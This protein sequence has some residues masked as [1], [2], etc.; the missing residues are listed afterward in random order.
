MTR[1]SA[2]HRSEIATYMG[3]AANGSKTQAAK[4][5]ASVYRVSVSTV[6]KAAGLGGTKRRRQQLRPEYRDWTRTVAALAARPPGLSFEDA[7][8][9]AVEGGSLPPEAAAMPVATAR[10]LAREMGL[11]KRPPRTQRMDGDYPMQAVLIDWSTSQY[12]LADRPQGDDW[13]LRLNRR[14][15]PASGYKNRP[16]KGHR[17]RVGVYC[18]W[19]M[20]TGYTISRY[21]VSKGENAIDAMAFLC[22]ALGQDKDPRLRMHG[23]PDDLWSDLGPLARSDAAA[24]LLSRLGV[25]LITGQPYSKSRMGGVERQHRTRWESFEP[26]LFHRGT[27]TLTLSE[28]NDRLVEFEI[29]E[30][31]KRGGSRTL[32]AGRRPSR[33]E[34]WTALTNARPADNP[35]RLLPANPMETLATEARRV[36]D[37]NGIVRWGGVEYECEA[38]HSRPVIARRAADGSGD[39]ALEDEATGER[40]VARRYEPRPY[41]TVRQAAASPLDKLATERAHVRPVADLYA[42]RPAP[43]GNVTA[44]PTRSE[45]PAPLDNPLAA[46]RLGSAADAMRLFTSLCP[47][48]LSAANMRL[49]RERIVE[50]GLSRQAVTELAQELSALLLR[51]G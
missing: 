44:M 48:R 9:V 42:P 11:E 30:N 3:A 20:C 31:D 18:L 46:D 27:E 17:Q 1:L 47:K 29:L 6:Y 36:V 34:A 5:L 49:V 2:L 15:V 21:S 8:R 13:L 28:L 14:P 16:L 24:D 25:A 23:V 41:G 33:A 37:V 32:V 45:P 35:L 38:W 7:L 19:D 4:H 39:L 50:S 26:T 22:W 40:R 10:R 12:V 43:A 51:E